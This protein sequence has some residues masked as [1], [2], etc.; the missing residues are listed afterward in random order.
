MQACIHQ[1][2]H[3]RFH[4]S[5]FPPYTGKAV[6]S[7]GS[8]RSVGASSPFCRVRLT[9]FPQILCS[10]D[11]FLTNRPLRFEWEKPLR[12]N[13]RHLRCEPMYYL[14]RRVGQDWWCCTRKLQ[15]FHCI[16][17]RMLSIRREFY[18]HFQL[19]AGLKQQDMHV[20]SL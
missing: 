6:R 14:P 12:P 13:Q 8:H 4:A 11:G 5:C 19:N 16:S 20:H 1:L 7:S 3:S 9:P 15:S 18:V 2:L 10:S 17:I